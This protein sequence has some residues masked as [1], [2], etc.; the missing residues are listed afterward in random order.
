MFTTSEASLLPTMRP[1]CFLPLQPLC[2]LPLRPLCFLPLRPLCF[3]T[4]RPLC[5][6]PVWSLW[7]LPVL[8][9]CFLPL[10]PLCFLH[11]WSCCFLPVRPLCFLPVRPLCF[12][13]VRPLCFLPVR[14]L[15]CSS[16]WFS[17]ALIHRRSGWEWSWD[18]IFLF[19]FSRKILSN[20]FMSNSDKEKILLLVWE[21]LFIMPQSLGKTVFVTTLAENRSAAVC[22]ANGRRFRPFMQFR[23]L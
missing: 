1:L 10:R 18:E 22:H 17:T 5:L 3:L 6:L 13:P 2:F 20:M 11:V 9:L 12:L 15:Y 19:L 7:F 8:P 4:L 23:Y 21:N 16:T 14:P